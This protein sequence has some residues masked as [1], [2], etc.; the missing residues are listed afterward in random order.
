MSSSKD[1]RS[2][3]FSEGTSNKFWKIELDGAS[4]TV[5]FGRV[6]T[7]GQRQVKDFN[8]DAAARKS[9]DKLVA[10]KVKKG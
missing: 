8:D 4:H 2:L 7:A 1:S 5:T 3:V 6:G 10:E 9:F